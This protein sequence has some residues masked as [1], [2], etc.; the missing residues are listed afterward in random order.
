[1]LQNLEK[2]P[3]VACLRFEEPFLGSRLL[4]A[5]L[6][7]LHLL[8]ARKSYSRTIM[9]SFDPDF[10]MGLKNHKIVCVFGE[11]ETYYIHKS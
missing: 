7:D 5:D 4:R 6:D 1:M 3:A 8:V 2:P 9:C 11:L 10:S